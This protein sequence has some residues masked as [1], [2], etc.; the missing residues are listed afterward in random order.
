[1]HENR[2]HFGLGI[3]ERGIIREYR[4]LFAQAKNRPPPA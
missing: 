3:H 4:E 1:M 2:I